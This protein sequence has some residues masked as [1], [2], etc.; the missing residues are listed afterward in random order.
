MSPRIS[1]LAWSRWGWFAV[2]GA[3]V[4]GKDACLGGGKRPE[5]A[6][7]AVDAAAPPA[8]PPE[9]GTSGFATPPPQP[10]PPPHPVPPG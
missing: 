3:L 1:R 8:P 4:A 5:P 6:A 7:P 9:T 2:V 10:V